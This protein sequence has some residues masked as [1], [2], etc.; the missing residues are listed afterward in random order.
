MGGVVVLAQFFLH[1]VY[2]DQFSSIGYFDPPIVWSPGQSVGLN[3]LAE[4]AVGAGAE[5]Y[6]LLGYMAEPAGNT[7]APDQANL[8]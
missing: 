2:A 1:H 3:L 4:S 7:V 6:G 5:S 8:V